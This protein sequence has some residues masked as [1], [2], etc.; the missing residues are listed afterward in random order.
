MKLKC[1]IW[2]FIHSHS[3]FLLSPSPI[4]YAKSIT[5]SLTI[6]FCWEYIW[7]NYVVFQAAMKY[8]HETHTHAR[9]EGEREKQMG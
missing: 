7:I 9:K 6:G 1:K 4:I 2:Y 3:F 8:R 5:E